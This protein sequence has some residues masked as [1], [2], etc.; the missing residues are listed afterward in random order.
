[1][2]LIDLSHTINTHISRFAEQAPAP[3][4]QPWMTHAEAT[5]SGRYEDCSCEI[6]EI[7]M[8]TSM[9]TYMDAPY[10]FVPDGPAIHQIDLAQTVLP[11]VCVD[12]GQLEP[13]QEIG[14]DV[15]QGIDVKDC[16]VLFCTRWD[17]YWGQPQY[18]QYPFLGR[19]VAEY[20]R[21][22]GAKL[23][24][25]DYLSA[26]NQNDPRRPVHTTLLRANIL[27]VENLTGLAQLI[28][29]SFTFHAAPVK[30]EGA[31]AFPVRAYAVMA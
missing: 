1:M 22:A 2:R 17:Q 5:A 3:I 18:M 30:I 16:A 11:G 26:D 12:C 24:G 19:A 27:I 10:H 13:H 4:I 6:T 7:R 23:V 25:V 29:E 31:A 20:L 9:G 28:G 8:L 14:L 15:V 21:E